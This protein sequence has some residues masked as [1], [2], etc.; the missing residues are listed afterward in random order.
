MFML[1]PVYSNFGRA[2]VEET[3]T[4]SVASVWYIVHGQPA[5]TLVCVVLCAR[6]PALYMQCFWL[7]VGGRWW[8]SRFHA[9]H[10]SVYMPLFWWMASPIARTSQP[11]NDTVYE[12]GVCRHKTPFLTIWQFIRTRIGVRGVEALCFWATIGSVGHAQFQLQKARTSGHYKAFE[13]FF[14][15]GGKL[16]V[17]IRIE[18]I[19]RKLSCWTSIEC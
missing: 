8:C 19:F 2:G 3:Y 9:P 18:N 14:V 15:N 1:S 12:Y 6:S 13:Y 10:P 5:F 7:L 11:P 4:G 16:F 17:Q